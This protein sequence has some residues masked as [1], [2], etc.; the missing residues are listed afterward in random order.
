MQRFLRIA[1]GALVLALAG[2]GCVA[3]RAPVETDEQMEAR[4]SRE[5][6]EDWPAIEA[7]RAKMGKKPLQPTQ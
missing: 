6:N 1:L 3:Q 2:T 7:A 4:I 5:V